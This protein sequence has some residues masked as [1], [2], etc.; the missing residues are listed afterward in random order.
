MRDERVPDRVREDVALGVLAVVAPVL[1]GADAAVDREL[2][3]VARKDQPTR[4]LLLLEQRAAVE[5]LGLEG[6]RL[7][8]GPARGED[9]EHADHQHRDHEQPADLPVHGI[10]PPASAYG[11]R[12]AR[13]L[14]ISSSASSTKLATTDE[15]PY[16]TNGSV[17]PVSGITRVT[18]P[19][20]TNTWSANTDASPAE[21]SFEKPSLA[22][23]AVL[24]P[25]ETNSR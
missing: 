6:V 14:T 13:S 19:T 9:R 1:V 22:I 15:P 16:E 10:S 5:R 21:R 23:V 11:P 25:R 7:Q 2:G 3:A 24:K 8:H 17:T 20:I 4:D 18:P 12:R